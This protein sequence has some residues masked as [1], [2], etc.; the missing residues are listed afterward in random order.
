M[1]LKQRLEQIGQLHKIMEQ[2]YRALTKWKKKK[3][4]KQR[5]FKRFS[6]KEYNG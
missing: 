2:S 4:K 5:E 6:C 3:T 1:P